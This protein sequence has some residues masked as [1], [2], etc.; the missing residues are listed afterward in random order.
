[1]SDP[2]VFRLLAAAGCTSV[3]FGID[4]AAEEVLPGFGKS[5]TIED[6][7]KSTAAAKAAGM[8]V[9]HS[10]LF[11]GPGETPATVAE[12]VRVTDEAAPTAVVAMVGLRI[13]PETAL[14]RLARDAGLIGERQPLLEPRFYA[15]GHAS[16]ATRR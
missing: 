16:P 14:A 15:A 1:M 3:D 12:T 2:G 13:Y 6:I 8:D 7:R 4:T 10:L 5:F 11:G 9:C